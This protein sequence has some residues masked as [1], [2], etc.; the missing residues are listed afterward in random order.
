M[1][2]FARI[3]AIASVVLLLLSLLL[4]LG[5]TIFQNPIL[6]LFGYNDEFQF[7]I[8]KIQLFLQELLQLQL[9]NRFNSS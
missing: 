1:K 8:G 7:L 4:T 5:V 6:E 9:M 3:C 2:I